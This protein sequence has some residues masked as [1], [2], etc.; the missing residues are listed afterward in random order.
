[1]N[2]FKKH[3]A[4][5]VTTVELIVVVAILGIL[6]GIGAFGFLKYLPMYSLKTTAR[7]LVS[8][9]QTT[10]MQAIKTNQDHALVFDEATGRYWI[11]SSPGADNQWNATADNVV[12]RGPYDIGRNGHG[13]AYGSG[14]AT[15]SISGG[16][17]PADKCPDPL[18]FDVRGR[19]ASAAGTVYIDNSGGDTFAVTVRKTGSIVMRHWEGG[20]W[21]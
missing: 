13:V 12:F 9:L 1:M 4:R 21:K 16:A 7:E 15:T 17:L 14:G 8:A 5:G 10:K 3:D 11:C 20:T 6:I 2:Q 19:L 18:V